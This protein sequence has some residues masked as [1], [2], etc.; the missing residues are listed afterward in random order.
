MTGNVLNGGTTNDTTPTLVGTAEAGAV[1]AVRRNG[2]TIGTTTANG[3]G[4]WTLTT[5]AL[6]G[7]TSTLTATATDAAGNTSSVSANY[8][9]TIDTAAPLAPLIVSVTDDRPNITG[10]V[11]SGGSTNDS[12]LQLVGTAEPNATVVV[13]N[14]ATVI[15]SATADGSGNWGFTTPRLADGRYSLTATASDAAGNT[16]PASS[17]AYVVT[18]DTVAPSRAAITSVVDDVGSVRGAVP[19]GGRTDDTTLLVSGTAEPGSL[20]VVR[21]DTTILKR[22]Y[23]DAFGNWSLTTP[24][25]AVQAHKLNAYA[26]D[27][28]GNVGMKSPNHTITIDQTAPTI[29]SFGTTA[30]AGTFGPGAE[31]PIFAVATEQ[32]AAGSAIDVTLNTGTVVRLAAATAGSRL[33]GTYRVIPGGLASP[34]SIVAVANATPIAADIAGNQV[35]GLPAVPFLIA[36]VS[37]DAAIRAVATG[38]SSDPAAP[39]VRNAAVTSIQI[40]FSTEVTG[41]STAALRLFYNQ[42]ESISLRDATITG[43]G[44]NYTLTLPSNL[45]N[46]LGSYRLVIGPSSGILAVDGLASMTLESNAYWTRV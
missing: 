11:T 44:R 6:A 31:I 32:L 12:E 39:S 10:V 3:S 17:P 19:F 21:T 5:P 20:V 16:S 28:A 18:V 35:A 9:V 4:L 40:V 46:R 30:A 15:G 26:R 13:R 33:T 22:V 29:L 38:F 23:A 45:T 24:A 37:V 7:G 2:S 43:S 8:V 42:R 14:G 27:A 1:I 41:V 34:L 25:L 36:G